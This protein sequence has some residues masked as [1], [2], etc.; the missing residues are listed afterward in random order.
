MTQLCAT[1][2]N[3]VQLYKTYMTPLYTTELLNNSCKIYNNFTIYTTLQDFETIHIF[4]TYFAQLQKLYTTLLLYAYLQS[5]KCNTSILSHTFTTYLHNFVYKQIFNINRNKH[6]ST[7]THA[8][9]KHVH[10]ST[11]LYP[12]LNTARNFTTLQLT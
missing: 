2:H 1:L 6:K 10:N 7:E 3:S 9:C 8:Q 5:R 12:Q 11:N 4:Y